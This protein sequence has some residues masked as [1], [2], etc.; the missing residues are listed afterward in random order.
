M[1]AKAAGA[2]AAV[3]AEPGFVRKYVFSTDHKV[4]GIQYMSTFFV[5]LLLSGAVALVIRV[6]MLT[7]GTSF[8]RPGV[9]NEVMGLHQGCAAVIVLAGGRRTRTARIFSPKSDP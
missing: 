9:Y 8:L 5:V 4:I 3:S 2:A 1:A 7:P 6:E